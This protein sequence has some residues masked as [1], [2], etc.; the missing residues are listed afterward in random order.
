[1]LVEGR[2]LTKVFKSG[3]FRRNVAVDHVN[4][5]IDK[6]E[7]L[8]LIGE[9]GSGKTTLGRLLLYL[10]KPDSGEVF[11][12]GCR[13]D[14]LKP[15]EMRMMRKRMQLIPQ[16]PEDALDPRWKI[17][18]SLLEPAEIH[19]FEVNLKELVS[20]VGL[21]EEHLERY[22]H[23]LSGGELQRVVIARAVSLNPDFIVADEPTSMLD[24]SV[25]AS[26]INLLRELQEDKKVAYLFIT[27]DVA[28]A[29]AIADRV[30]V[31]F[32]GEIVEKGVDVLEKP[33]HPFSKLLIDGDLPEISAT[34]TRGCKFSVYC[35]RSHDICKITK[36][37]LVDFGDKKVK[38]HIYAK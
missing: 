33:L 6:S 28:L 23:E 32:K 34:S 2:D 10:T 25:Q 3:F 18:K 26:I 35:K 13:L 16:H 30:A 29:K 12:D 37:S 9:S 36:P 24:V 27:H 21:K 17:R 4:I 19:G 14:T 15:K 7:T 22:P 11:F 1:M 31:M 38:C 5:S 20:L 8:V